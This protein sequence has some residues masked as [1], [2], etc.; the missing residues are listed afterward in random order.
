V[1]EKVARLRIKSG[2]YG[3]QNEG[4]LRMDTNVAYDA[5]AMKVDCKP[6]DFEKHGLYKLTHGS[7][8]Y[9]GKAEKQSLGKRLMQHFNKAT[10]KRNLT[11]NVDEELRND[12]Y[13]DNWKLQILPVQQGDIS[14]A[15]AFFIASQQ[16]NL[17]VQRPRL[18]Y[19]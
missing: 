1:D 13:A 14:A 2:W 5:L 12:P 17:N 10:S 3:P 9:I 15:E 4:R 8:V 19:N 18:N 7:D 6:K 16:P 11:G